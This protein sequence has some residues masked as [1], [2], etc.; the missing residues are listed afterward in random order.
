MAVAISGAVILREHE[1]AYTNLVI[2]RQRCDNCG[3]LPPK[4]PINVSLLPHETVAYGTHHAE[5]F[6]CPFCENPQV[7]K[8][9]G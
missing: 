6:I 7:V 3:Y 4:S 9:Q 8:I 5:S 1:G 2:Y